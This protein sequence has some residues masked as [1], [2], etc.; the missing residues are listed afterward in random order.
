MR[1][2]ISVIGLGYSSAISF[3]IFG[4]IPWRIKVFLKVDFAF[5]RFTTVCVTKPNDWSASLEQYRTSTKR[6]FAPMA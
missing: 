1:E 4:G 3:A 5:R 6:A 2:K